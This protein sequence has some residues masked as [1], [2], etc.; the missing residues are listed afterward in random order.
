MTNCQS[1]AARPAAEF[2]RLPLASHPE[3][4]FYSVGTT[5]VNATER[6]TRKA[7]RVIPAAF[8]CFVG[9]A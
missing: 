1:D 4:W 7:A 8:S 9:R 6:D 3:Q 2:V 5:V